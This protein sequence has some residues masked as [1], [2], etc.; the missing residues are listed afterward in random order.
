MKTNAEIT[1]VITPDLLALLGFMVA[2]P[3]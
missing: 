2:F 1:E 3:F